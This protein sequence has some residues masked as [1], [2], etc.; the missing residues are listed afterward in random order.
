MRY[1]PWRQEDK[2]ALRALVES[3][4]NRG[5]TGSHGSSIISQVPEG[6]PAH[7]FSIGLIDAGPFESRPDM[8][9]DQLLACGAARVTRTADGVPQYLCFAAEALCELRLELCAN[10]V[11]RHAQPIPPTFPAAGVMMP[12]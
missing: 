10:D 8:V 5:D 6:K 2:P 3:R 12:I 7:S 11:S 9:V 1:T 4:L